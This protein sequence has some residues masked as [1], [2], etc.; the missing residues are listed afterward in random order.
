MA[1]FGGRQHEISARFRW[2]PD[3]RGYAQVRA[4]LSAM[5]RATKNSM[6]RTG[7]G[8]VANLARGMNQ[9]TR[10]VHQA[11]NNLVSVVQ[12]HAVR[13]GGVFQQLGFQA[14]LAGSIMTRAF[15]AP[16]VAAAGLGT[17]VGVKLAA[18][19]ESAATSLGALLPVGYNV[20]ALLKRLRATA[21][22][23]PVFD[24][25]QLVDFTRKLVASGIE[26]SKTE[27]II[28]SMGKVFQTF[29]VSGDAA[30]LALR[31]ITQAFSKGKLQ[32]EELTGQIGEQIPALALLSRAA[33]VSQA[34]FL[35]M[36]TAGKI[37]ADVLDDLLIKI[38]TF[39]EIN[40]GATA[41]LNTMQ[42][43]W[44]RL[45]E[46]IFDALA[47]TWLK[48]SPQIQKSLKDIEN[49][50]PGMLE[51]F[52]PLVP[53]IV[54]GF[55]AIARA[56]I[57]VVTWYNNLSESAQGLVRTFALIAVAAGP[58]I[59][60]FGK[61]FTILGFLFAIV[62]A[63]STPMGLLGGAFIAIGAAV[64]IA[65]A[66][67]EE[68][69]AVFGYIFEDVSNG[70]KALGAVLQGGG[71]T[72]DGFVGGMEKI[73]YAL[74]NLKEL[75]DK[76]GS[77]L[78]DGI[79]A[80]FEAFHWGTT[81]SG[82]EG[83]VAFMERVG[84]AL[85]TLAGYV[86]TAVVQVIQGISGMFHAMSGEG[87]T[88]DGFVGAMERV[89]VVL[90]NLASI[91]GGILKTAF[92]ILAPIFTAIII[93]A[94]KLLASIV[95]NIV[96]PALVGITGFIQR[97]QTWFQALGVA[98]LAA[99]AAFK[100]YIIVMK[101]VAMFKTFFALMKGFL[102]LKYGIVVL[103]GLRVALLGLF[104][105][106]PIG[107]II[108]AVAGLVAAFIV[109]YKNSE[110]FRNFI[111]KLGRSLVQAGRDIWNALKAMGA[112]FAE[113]WNFIVGG[114]K[115]A[116]RE[117]VG[118]FHALRTGI[119]NVFNSIRE[120]IVTSLPFKILATIVKIQFAVISWVINTARVL[121]LIAFKLIGLGI[122]WL[123]DRFKDAA[124]LIGMVFRWIG[125][126]AVNFY[127]AY[128][129]PVFNAFASFVTTIFRLVMSVFR[130]W[131]GGV[132][133]GFNAVFGVI[134]QW[135]SSIS[136]VF[137]TV[138]SYIRNVLSAAFNFLWKGVIVPVFN[139]IRNTISVTWNRYIWPIFKTIM[140]VITRDVPGA[141]SRGVGAIG[142]FF[143]NLG[144]ILK[145]P[146][147]WVISYVINRG[148]IAPIN[149]VKKALGVGGKDI[150]WIPTIGGS[151][152]RA[153]PVQRSGLT[154]GLAK[155]GR[156][157]GG[158]PGKDTIPVM[159]MQDEYVIRTKS[160]RK[161]GFDRLEYMNRTGELP[162][163]AKGGRV[164]GKRMKMSD[165]PSQSNRSGGP[166]DFLSDLFM[167][168]I[169]W[170]TNKAGIGRIL[171]KFKNLRKSS[172]GDI[173]VGG[174]KKLLNMAIEKITSWLGSFGGD[175]GGTYLGRDN[176]NSI[177]AILTVARRFYRGAR[178][179]SGYRPGDPGYHGRGLAADLIGGGARG[180][181]TIARGFMGMSGRLLELIHSGG[182]GMFVKNGKRVGAGYYR[183]VIGQH[184]NHVH[185]AARKD[186]LFARLALGSGGGR[187]G[188][189]VRQAMGITA[190]PTSWYNA[191]VAL[192]K[193]ESG[194][195]PRAINLTDS[196]AKAGHPSKG[197]FQTIDSTFNRYSLPG[198]KNIWN[199]V[200]NAVAAIRY[201]RSRYG[202]IF[203]IPSYRSGNRFVGGY[204]NGTPFVPQTGLALVHK[205]ERI[206][207]ANQNR[208]PIRPYRRGGDDGAIHVHFEG[209]VMGHRD[210]EDA[211]TGIVDQLRRK[212][213]LPK[214]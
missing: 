21:I 183:S 1:I 27:K 147:N 33:G 171:D 90:R 108:A 137:N 197:L 181:A 40:K 149:R 96:L 31:G 76:G 16:A 180:M 2:T 214:R 175:G 68:L 106:N 42:G 52:A 102:L 192:A 12:K 199:P 189:W 185:V 123:I 73:G 59:V 204:A 187:L 121:I 51:A 9:G 57:A 87:V 132:T 20:E 129:R 144:N 56:V 100:G 138:V 39:P 46:S 128:I 15:T 4:Q 143:S 72:S 7:T 10:R 50:I 38:G 75:F 85:R 17:A 54:A 160:A 208:G 155:G 103:N 145:V 47:M 201:I 110:T 125:D 188:A 22:K 202:S 118:A 127:Q 25:P 170:L 152:P 164:H 119:V 166:L 77:Q 3:A 190:A 173:V 195:N 109:A 74:R 148:I 131:W 18:K 114:A 203:N 88:S 206:I 101:V 14:N 79:T 191:L 136:A 211:V 116:W 169:K 194:G 168:P 5:E 151:P 26:V 69:R 167:D 86:G 61:I 133:T 156:L 23:S 200:H 55:V 13:M 6:H 71:V 153:A 95:A 176:S 193:H 124:K 37:T 141:F 112:A 210:L 142:K 49:Q 139:S 82:A 24:T 130:W 134:K 178:V 62:N 81:S 84:L 179:S 207:P 34:E 70:V 92:A 177:N 19:L 66:K 182:G 104:L 44:D 212:G 146:I 11:G 48:Y 198:M 80:M 45:K 78:V 126:Q 157:R 111:N 60:V 174:P 32:A 205:G 91:A 105:G 64:G 89:G 35:K 163:Y 83:F 8:A 140:K 120:A 172:F 213:R 186:A 209:P 93:P 67:S 107:L 28:A 41:S 30:N 122:A 99:W 196:N 53:A 98:V 94:F 117:T 36:V 135:W 113:I 58:V 184:Y 154:A 159:A 43:A 97:N 158:I 29:G 150:G 161:L 162:G 165:K 115:E 63:L 65:A